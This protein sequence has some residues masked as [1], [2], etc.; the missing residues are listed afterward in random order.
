MHSSRLRGTDFSI[1]YRGQDVSHA[2]FFANFKYTDR[3]GLLAP[4]R[5]D[6]LGAAVLVMAYVTAFYDRYRERGV[7]FFAYPDFFSFQE[8]EPVANYSMFDI[9]PHHKNVLIGGEQHERAASITDRAVGV[10]LVPED[11]A[12]EVTIEPVG[13]ASARRNIRRC[14]AYSSSGWAAEADLAVSCKDPDLANWAR[15][16]IDSVPAS[17]PDPRREYW[18]R[19]IEGGCMPEQKFREIPLD[20]ALAAI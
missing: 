15:K 10:L 7:D 6:G 17:E 8:S 14:F 5:F 11:R 18:E 2:R 19:T 9:W 20:Q 16:V 3:V 13:M 12:C 4:T 1:T